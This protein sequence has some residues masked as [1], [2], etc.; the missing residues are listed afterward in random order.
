MCP[1]VSPQHDQ[2][3]FP[4][5]LDSQDSQLASPQPMVP[6]HCQH[7]ITLPI[8]QDV[9]NPSA[10]TDLQNDLEPTIAVTPQLSL[11]THDAKQPPPVQ[12]SSRGIQ[13]SSTAEKDFQLSPPVLVSQ[14]GI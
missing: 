9:D 13:Q 4:L 11:S 1:V 3:P 5:L 14:E 8:S 7:P 10:I 12:P 6:Q 2:Q